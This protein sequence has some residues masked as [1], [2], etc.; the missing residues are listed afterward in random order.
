MPRIEYGKSL[1]ER[2][3]ELQKLFTDAIQKRLDDFARTRGYDG[4]DSMAKYVGCSVPKFAVESAYMRDAA[5]LTWMK[6]Y[7]LLARYAPDEASGQIAIPS[8]ADIEA[9]LP[10]LCWPDE[11]AS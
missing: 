4:V 10:V 6:G 11:E 1:E 7:E 3:A 2:L 8:W 5:A 9:E